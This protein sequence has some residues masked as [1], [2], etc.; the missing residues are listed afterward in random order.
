M[1]VQCTIEVTAED[2]YSCDLTRR[3]P[4]RVSIITINGDTGFGIVEPTDGREQSI[5]DYVNAMSSSGSIKRVDVTFSSPAGYWTEVVHHMGR[6]SIYET[7][8][9]SGCMTQ[10]P[11]VIQ[12]GIQTHRVLAPSRNALRDLLKTLRLRF[13]KVSVKQLKSTKLGGTGITLTE[14]QKEA[15]LLAIRRGY[16]SIPR[17]VKL[18]DLC[19]ELSIKRVAIQERLRRAEIQILNSYAEELLGN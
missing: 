11:V 7:V 14:K 10:L 18:E 6:P 9:Q 12:Q 2:Y 8:L 19:K 5:K 4:V 13:A 17:G 15:F 16:Y 1:V 3:I